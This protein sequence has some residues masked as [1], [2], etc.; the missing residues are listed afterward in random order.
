MERLKA[1]WPL[2]AGDPE[3]TTVPQQ[4]YVIDVRR[5]SFLLQGGCLVQ[6]KAEYP[7]ETRVFWCLFFDGDPNVV[8]VPFLDRKRSIRDVIAEKRSLECIRI[9]SKTIRD[10]V[11]EVLTYELAYA[12]WGSVLLVK[13]LDQHSRTGGVLDWP[14]PLLDSEKEKVEACLRSIKAEEDTDYSLR[15]E[16][17]M[18]ELDALVWREFRIF[19]KDNPGELDPG[20]KGQVKLG[21]RR[22][23]VLLKGLPDNCHAKP[24]ASLGVPE[25]RFPPDPEGWEA[26]PPEDASFILSDLNRRIV[27]ALDPTQLGRW[28]RQRLTFYDRDL[29]R[30]ESANSDETRTAYILRKPGF[31]LPLDS[32]SNPIHQM[33]EIVGA[34]HGP[35]IRTKH[36]AAAYVEFFCRHLWVAPHGPF[37]VLK[38]KDDNAISRLDLTDADFNRDHFDSKDRALA[39]IAAPVP[40]EVKPSGVQPVSFAVDAWVLYGEAIFKA[41]FSVLAHG[42]ITMTDDRPMV[43]ALSLPIHRLNEVLRERRS[44]SGDGQVIRTA[45][46][47]ASYVALFP[48]RVWGD[49]APF[50]VLK[51]NDDAA[52]GQLDLTDA[53]CDR[54]D[55]IGAALAAIAAPAA[56][57]VEPFGVQPAFEVAAWVLY[58]ETIFKATF[59][60][61]ADGSIE[62]TDH[63]EML[64][65][66][67]KDN[68]YLPYRPLKSVID[69]T[70]PLAASELDTEYPQLTDVV[71]KDR[72]LTGQLTREA[73]HIRNFSGCRFRGRVNLQFLVSDRLSFEQCVFENGLDLSGASLKGELSL[74]DCLVVHGRHHELIDKSKPFSLDD[75]SADGLRVDGLS[76]TSSLSASRVRI[77]GAVQL[78][79]I[80]TLGGI[81]F[82][83]CVIEQS[84]YF[85]D[86]R[87]GKNVDGKTSIGLYGAV[88]N[89]NYVLFQDATLTGDLDARYL[90]VGTGF[91]LESDVPRGNTIEGSIKLG[92]ADIPKLLRIRNT[93]VGKS[94][95]AGGVSTAELQILRPT[96]ANHL[97]M[98]GL[99]CL[100]AADITGLDLS[101]HPPTAESQDGAVIADLATFA[102]KLVVA[103]SLEEG[104]TI[105]GRLDLSGSTIGELAV[106]V[107]SFEEEVTVENLKLHGI[108]LSQAQINKF[109]AIGSKGGYPRPI[110]LSFSEIKWW[111]F[112]GEGGNSESDKAEDYLQL[113]EGDPHK[114][115]HTFSSIEQNLFN[116]GLDDAADDVHVA[117]RKWLRGEFGRWLKN[118]GRS[119]WDFWLKNRRRSVWDSWPK[120]RGRS[121]RDLLT[122]FGRFDRWLS[123][124]VRDVWTRFG[125]W[126]GRSLWDFFTLSTTSPLLLL[127]IVLISTIFSAVGVFSN[128]ANIGPSETGL[129]A[130]P[131]WTAATVPSDAEWNWWS[132]AWMAV[133]FHVPVAVL[134]A[135]GE[136]APANGRKLTVSLLHRPIC[137]RPICNWGWISPEDYANLVLGLHFLIWPVI[138]IIGSRKFFM[139]L[140]K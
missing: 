81:D 78:S 32:T 2:R 133:R 57:E 58:G 120:N 122:L 30:I 77:H 49:D 130:H 134:T 125:H 119:V 45:A 90:R 108:L 115:R 140:G 16:A 44:K 35:V 69:P 87:T 82:G 93:R 94:I 100:G 46:D 25:V 28:S 6:V 114:Q 126:L 15:V 70:E 42:A 19:T 99:K 3:P 23:E 21:K 135:R 95:E 137:N 97:T 85:Q 89:Y 17:C 111:E 117:M 84:M 76:S 112:R 64:S 139:R 13:D 29:L 22:P 1:E 71:V 5:P 61:L 9:D 113:L 86:V 66:G 11:V 18:V 40:R 20:K 102:K 8:V 73:L 27:P 48:R 91:F 72:V 43:S 12:G 56:T 138:L 52:I 74:T 60:V 75:L 136:W 38:S 14:T 51:S 106:S 33:N 105:P 92:G 129:I 26:V 83:Q 107:R 110:D 50:M 39:A 98:T 68:S 127:I 34:E 31:A 109:S 116:R 118:R 10:Y 36:Q 121:V 41:T 104:A 103:K 65:A 47:A 54:F 132:G 80:V 128:P 7:K 101:G 79:E 124:S 96:T 123:R 4:V 24:G 67:G 37:I 88:I 59:K 55:S 131:E 62:M 63:D 53:K